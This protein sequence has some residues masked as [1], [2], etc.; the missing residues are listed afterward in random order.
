MT[1][2]GAAAAA[3]RPVVLFAAP[4]SRMEELLASYESAKAAKED[5]GARF[6]AL[7]A[8]L[9]NEL[10][11]TAPAGS[12]DIA[13]AGP[14]GLPRLRMRWKTPYRFNSKQFKEDNPFL[15]VQYEVQG[16]FWELRLADG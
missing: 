12:T 3:L 4:G 14:P 1:G 8:A 2:P 10:A 15:Y 6:D 16:G 9:K 5:A 13:L 7:V 11:A